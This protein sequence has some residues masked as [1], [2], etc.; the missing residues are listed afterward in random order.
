LKCS[1]EIG[2]IGPFARGHVK[3][4][5]NKCKWEGKEIEFFESKGIFYSDFEVKGEY[6]DTFYV[7]NCLLRYAGLPEEK[8][9]FE[10]ADTPLPMPNITDLKPGQTAFC[11]TKKGRIYGTC[12]YVYATQVDLSRQLEHKVA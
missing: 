4:F 9:I 8:D 11:Y 12:G 1:F 6:K 3:N 5:L 7:L 2:N 10:D